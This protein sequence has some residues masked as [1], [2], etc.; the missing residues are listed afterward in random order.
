LDDFCDQFDLDLETESGTLAGYVM[1]KFGGLPEVGQNY[2]DEDMSITIREM[3]VQ[4]IISAE[5]TIFPK[6]EEGDEDEEAEKPAYSEE[7]ND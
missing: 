1:E 2:T 6:K 5:V 4:R 3:D 7:E